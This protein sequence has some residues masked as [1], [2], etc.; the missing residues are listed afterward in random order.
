VILSMKRNVLL[1]LITA[2]LSLLTLAGAN[3]WSV[4]TN[5]PA[6]AITSVPFT[7][8]KS[9]NYYLAT[10][11]TLPIPGSPAIIITASEVILDLNGRTLSGLQPQEAQIGILV[12]N[13]NDVIVQE[14][15]IDNFGEGIM[16]F[17]GSSG[18]NAKN[19]V[20]NVRFNNNQIAVFD[21]SGT[22]NWVKQCVIDG[23]DVGVFLNDANGDRVSHSIFE[24]Q[25]A[26]QSEH[27]GIPIFSA[28]S[29]GNLFDE[30]EIVHSTTPG[31]NFFG[32]VGS[33]GDKQRFNTYI[34][35]RIL[36]PFVGVFDVGA[37]SEN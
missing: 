36:F 8:S 32:L 5:V 16:W 21:E 29:R 18:L 6:T 26:S 30:N 7:I 9:G 17:P 25:Q 15:N 14:G 27:L 13:A 37:L 10:N 34:G 19:L 2:G 4:A 3:A 23:G 20:E 22:S 28:S 31:G 33:N 1:S 35:Y 12:D 24:E 11:L